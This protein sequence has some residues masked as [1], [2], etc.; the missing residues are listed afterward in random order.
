MKTI[1]LA[2]LLLF[3]APAMNAQGYEHLRDMWSSDAFQRHFM[4]TYGVKSEVEPDITEVEQGVM[5]QVRMLMEREGGDS[6]ARRY[7]EKIITPNDSAIYDYTLANIYFQQEKL[8]I[9]EKWYGRAT[10]KFPPFL[11][12]HKN[13]GI[14]QVRLEKFEDAIE[15]LTRS[16]ELG[17]ADHV[18]YGLLAYAHMSEKAFSSAETAYRMALMLKPD[19][20]DWKLGLT[21]TLFQQQKFETAASLAGELLKEDP[22]NVAFW[23]MQAN[24]YMGMQ[25]L[26]QAAQ[27]YEYLRARELAEPPHLNSLG[28][29][30]IK[31]EHLS[32]AAEAYQDAL[33]MDSAGDPDIYLRNAEFLAGRGGNVEAESLLGDIRKSFGDQ[34]TVDQQ[35]RLLKLRARTSSALGK[36]DEAQEE[37][38][39]EIVALDGLDGEALLL[40]GRHYARIGRAEEAYFQFE[41]AANLD[42]FRGEALLRHGQTLVRNKQYKQALPLL[43]QAQ[44]LQP[45][46]D[47]AK[48]IEQVKRVA[49]L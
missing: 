5:D 3:S 42:D 16:M 48:F 4:G 12:A 20:T 8:E 29:I 10:K 14:V 25:D 38:L 36:S 28:D 37:I 47:L 43:Q 27:N 9:A 23:V 31:K 33:K 34:M 19:Q 41:R 18:T 17:A 26:E 30:Y 46:D 11:R 49:G 21:R 1:H 45:N 24:A 7:L 44:D 32:L 35:K 40:L 13:L 15:S 6:L 39:A 22:E 2:L